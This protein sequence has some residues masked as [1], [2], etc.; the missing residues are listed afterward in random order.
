VL[1]PAP[2]APLLLLFDCAEAGTAAS[3]S[4]VKPRANAL[5]AADK[6]CSLFIKILLYLA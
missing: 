1:L 5:N 2:A 3:A 6:F 4:S